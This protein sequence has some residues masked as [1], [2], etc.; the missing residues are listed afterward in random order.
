MIVHIYEINMDSGVWFL[1]DHPSRD[2][3]PVEIWLASGA[4]IAT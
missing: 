1:P 4:A 3:L 2:P